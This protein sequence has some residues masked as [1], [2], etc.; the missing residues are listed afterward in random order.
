MKT[1]CY[2]CKGTGFVI[3]QRIENSYPC[4]DG[5]T[6]YCDYCENEYQEHEL[7]ELDEDTHICNGCLEQV[8]K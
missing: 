2:E 8:P 3:G 4:C 1:A 5:Y 7:E 6:Y